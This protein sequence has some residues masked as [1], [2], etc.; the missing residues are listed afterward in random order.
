LIRVDCARGRGQARSHN[1]CLIGGAG[2]LLGGG[3]DTGHH[4]IQLGDGSVDR[5]GDRPGDLRRDRGPGGE[6]AFRDLGEL[7]QEEQD[8][9]W[10][11][12][13]S[14]AIRAASSFRSRATRT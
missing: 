8:R 7:V 5:V 4:A 12:S 9:L 13:F 10:L 6:V 3:I 2:H 11:L 1:A 14:A